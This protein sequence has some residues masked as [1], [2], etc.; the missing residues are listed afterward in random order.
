[1]LVTCFFLHTLTAMSSLLGE[2]PTTMP[3]YTGVPGPMNSVPALL[4]VVE[5]VSD[6]FARF[7]GDEGAGLP[8]G[9]I[10]L[11]GLRSRERRCS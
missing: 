1:M 4:G 3:A 8:A 9:D 11:V 10:T 7:K 5:A 2:W 6:R